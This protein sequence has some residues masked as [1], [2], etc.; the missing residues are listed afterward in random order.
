MIEE[1]IYTS[2]EKGLK[3]GSRGFCTV[4]STAGMA[5]NTAERLESM[6]G[7][8]HAFPM[9][10][11]K[12]ALN[13]VNYS[14]VTLRIGG[15]NTH[16]ISRVADAGQDYSGRTNKL[17]HHLMI[18]DVSRMT[19]GPARL[20]AEK[21][22]L[23]SQWNGNVRTV[24]ARNLPVLAIPQS[25]EL[26]AWKQATG[27]S[28]WA[29]WV[30]EQLT[31]DKAPVSVIFQP[32]TDTLLL[33]REVLDL[34]PVT[35]QWLITFSTYFT[36]LLA[37][38]ECQLRFVLHDTPD[39]T[40]L[41]NDARAKVV[42]LTARLPECSGGPLV[43]TARAGQIQAARPSENVPTASPTLSRGATTVRSD[44]RQIATRTSA[45]I[46]AIPKATSPDIAL[47]NAVDC[48]I[49]SLRTF[50]TPRAR[51]K[52]SRA[53]L[54]SALTLVLIAISGVGFA[55][56]A[57]RATTPSLASNLRSS[58]ENSGQGEPSSQRKGRHVDIAAPQ[59]PS[60]PAN[61]GFDQTNTPDSGTSPKD[62]SQNASTHANHPAEP[63]LETAST[64]TIK[65]SSPDSQEALSSHP[66]AD[67]FKLIRTSK[68]FEY[69]NHPELR[70]FA[71]PSNPAT[72]KSKGLPLML[73]DGDTVSVAFH[74]SFHDVINNADGLVKAD[75]VRLS[76][77]FSESGHQRWTAEFVRAQAVADVYGHYQL[78]E[79]KT[80]EATH[81][82]EFI[83][84]NLAKSAKETEVLLSNLFLFCPLVVTVTANDGG[85]ST[86]LL[87]QRRGRVVEAAP[88]KVNPR[89]SRLDDPNEF[90][91]LNLFSSREK[92]LWHSILSVVIQTAN[93]RKSLPAIPFSQRNAVGSAYTKLPADVNGSRPF[94]RESPSSSFLLR[95]FGEW[96]QGIEP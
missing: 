57:N 43:Q 6:S 19:A 24:P 69:P 44:D 53:L 14:H 8:R 38:T 46:P 87:S 54:Y 86:I 39:A 62:M 1:I 37:G 65:S 63:T 76:G 40:A 7:Y 83:P 67:P 47:T 95:G 41:R 25:I 51:Q 90:G 75:D 59:L 2:A 64:T 21:G 16:V 79:D 27:D 42:D 70:L 20:M 45:E 71:I 77:P 81:V 60:L 96:N 36:K 26:K 32:G 50:D 89:S 92:P 73:R 17:A 55:V 35:Q 18:D 10:D 15:K 91:H 58:Q 74:N 80:G 52:R 93:G 23:V 31:K 4:V 5:I 29:G 28:G 66:P 3:A 33:V 13:P 78:R 94:L 72:A 34:L 84:D 61:Q 56:Y 82:L 22:V 30:A 12:A 85:V 68:E 48:R 11:P 49:P 9:Q 88:N